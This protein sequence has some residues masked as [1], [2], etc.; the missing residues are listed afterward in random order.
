VTVGGDLDTVDQLP[1]NLLDDGRRPVLEDLADLGRQVS[2]LLG[3]CELRGRRVEL[4]GQLVAVGGQLGAALGEFGDPGR[5]DHV[6]ILPGLE[7]SQVVAEAGLGLTERGLGARQLGFEAGRLSVTSEITAV[8]ASS[9]RSDR[10]RVRRRSSLT[11]ISRSSVE[12]P[13]P[14]ASGALGLAVP[15]SLVAV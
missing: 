5:A 12:T 4:T 15:A 8:M 13:A 6:G 7:R 3:G 2:E 1:Q 10:D 11:A 14:T 9:K